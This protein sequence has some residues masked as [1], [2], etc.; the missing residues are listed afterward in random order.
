MNSRGEFERGLLELNHAKRYLTRTFQSKVVRTYYTK[1]P[2][3]NY[4]RTE[5][6]S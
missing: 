3:N 2:Q 5:K 4:R 1:V 6:A